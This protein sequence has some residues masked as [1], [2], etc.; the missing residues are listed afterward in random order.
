MNLPNMPADSTSREYLRVAGGY[1]SAATGASPAGGLDADNAG[2][3]AADGDLT[4]DGDLDLRGALRNTTGDLTFDAPL[5]LGPDGVNGLWSAW[6]L[7]E[8]AYKS[9]TAGPAGP[10]LVW[11]G[12]FQGSYTTL[13]FD[14]T[15]REFACWRVPLPAD[16]DGSDLAVTVYWTA[17]S[18]TI[19]QSVVWRAH[20]ACF[21]DGDDIDQ[22]LPPIPALEDAYQT[23]GSC[24]SVTSTGSP[25][26]TSPGSLL[27]ANINRQAEHINDTLS[28]DARLLAVRITYA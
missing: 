27:V 17:A 15:T 28:A 26:Y 6:L 23:A 20:L 9:P 10:N 11:N 18:G 2:N 22:A 5:R 3:I 16:Y 1:G 14:P 13:D 25:A 7:P 19:G 21:A 4:L 8:T 24:H 12:D